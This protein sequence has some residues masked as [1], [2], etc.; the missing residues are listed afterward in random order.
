MSTI[1]ICTEH[2]PTKMTFSLVEGKLEFFN[3][4]ILG[5][6]QGKSQCLY[7]GITTAVKPVKLYFDVEW[8]QE[9]E[10]ARENALHR[11]M[12][13]VVCWNFFTGKQ[14]QYN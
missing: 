5:A 2:S 8:F 11:C 9:T 4:L 10:I 1:L 3:S 6:G 12:R 13:L 7:E 14:H